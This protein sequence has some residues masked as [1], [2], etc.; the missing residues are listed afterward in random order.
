ME[1]RRVRFLA[2]LNKVLL[3]QGKRIKLV[4]GE[5]GIGLTNVYLK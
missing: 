5:K 2:R 3:R 1:E 4:E